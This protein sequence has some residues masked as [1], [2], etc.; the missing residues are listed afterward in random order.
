MSI[1]VEMERKLFLRDYVRSR[2]Q[3]ISRTRKRIELFK[4]PTKDTQLQSKCSTIL[5]LR[6]YVRSRSQT[7]SRT[8][9]KNRTFKCPTRDICDFNRTAYGEHCGFFLLFALNFTRTSPNHKYATPANYKR[10][11][12]QNNF[13]L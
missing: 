11:L 6:N 9:K 3:T 8:R 2:S 12:V 4:C 1:A 5:F 10:R 7:I 13:N